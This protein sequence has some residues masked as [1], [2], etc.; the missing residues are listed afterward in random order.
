MKRITRD[1]IE[2]A[3]TY[4]EYRTNVNELFEQG[5]STGDNHSEA[6]MNYTKLN[7]F[8]MKRLDKTTRLT[9]NALAQIQ[10]ENRK[11]TWL[12]ITEA[13]CGDA[14]QIIP[15]LNK[16]AE[17]NENIS[18]KMILRDENLEVMDQ[19]L[20]NGT[21]SIPILI[22]LDSETLEVLNSWGPRP[23]EVQEMVMEAKSNAAN[24]PEDSKEIWDEA[25]KNAQLWYTKDKSKTIQAEILGIM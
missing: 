18:L 3:W 4:D 12:V 9:E 10:K 22:V 21:R 15:V 8:R 17:E 5:K 25:K 11:I 14:A 13:W 23:V 20:T 24:H 16:L 19:F 6:I 2:K 7:I 1:I